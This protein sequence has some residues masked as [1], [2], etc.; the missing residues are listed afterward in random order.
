MILRHS[1]RE[2]RNVPRLMATES[3]R[4]NH[5]GHIIHERSYT[6]AMYSYT[7]SVL[8]RAEAAQLWYGVKDL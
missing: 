2:G 6:I 1:T 3:F 5:R 4:V 8:T 7:I